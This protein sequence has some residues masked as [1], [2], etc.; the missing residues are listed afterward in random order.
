MKRCSRC[1]IEKEESYFYRDKRSSDELNCACKNCVNNINKEYGKK[2]PEIRK[3]IS[4][5]AHER[6]RE[7]ERIYAKEYAK[8]LRENNHEK[9]LKN[10]IKWEKENPDKVREIRKRAIK[11]WSNKNKE[12]IKDIQKKWIEKNLE[13]KRAYSRLGAKKA[14]EKFPEKNAARKMV[15]GAL[16]LGILI[17]PLNCSKC[18]KECKPEGHHPDYSKPLEVIWLCRQCHNKEHGK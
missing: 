11:K 17:R 16:T 13:K 7:K 1:K 6:N 10:K 3:K 15:S 12:K 8:N 18:L 14:R 4:K 9:Y 5:D 2:N